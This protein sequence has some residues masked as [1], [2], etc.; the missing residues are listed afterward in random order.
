MKFK[1]SRLYVVFN[2][3]FLQICFFLSHEG[4]GNSIIMWV[5]SAPPP[6]TAMKNIFNRLFTFSQ[7]VYS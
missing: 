7:L 5:Q 1:A 4:Q 3:K 6:F 2:W